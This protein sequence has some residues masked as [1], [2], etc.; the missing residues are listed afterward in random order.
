MAPHKCYV[1]HTTEDVKFTFP[2]DPSKLKRWCIL[3]KCKTPDTTGQWVNFM[4]TSSQ[5][6]YWTKVAFFHGFWIIYF[7]IWSPYWPLHQGWLDQ[8]CVWS[9]FLPVTSW[10]QKRP[11]SWRAVHCP[12]EKTH[13]QMISQMTFFLFREM[14]Y[15][16]H[17]TQ[18]TLPDEVLWSEIY[19]AIVHQKK[20]Q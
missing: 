18:P 15:N 6:M 4:L 16:S 9:I 2:S 14:V 5:I 19:S 10:W 3:L 20:L 13:C 1:C 8:G 11:P 17:Q 7:W 12:K